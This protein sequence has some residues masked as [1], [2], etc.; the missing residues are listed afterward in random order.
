[1]LDGTRYRPV[2]WKAECA[3]HEV[4]VGPLVFRPE[5]EIS[6]EQRVGKN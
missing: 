5:R 3:D 4:I 1:M 2:L 6:P